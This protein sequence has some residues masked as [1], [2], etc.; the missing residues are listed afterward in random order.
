M[1]RAREDGITANNINGHGEENISYRL[2]LAKTAWWRGENQ[3]WRT[4]RQHFSMKSEVSET[5]ENISERKRDLV[6]G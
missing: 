2:Y 3:Q 4:A 1:R 6:N 5:E